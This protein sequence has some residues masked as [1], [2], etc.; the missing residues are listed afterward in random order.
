[1]IVL[2]VVFSKSVPLRGCAEAVRFESV[3][4]RYCL[5]ESPS[6]NA[7]VSFARTVQYS[8]QNRMQIYHQLDA[9]DISIN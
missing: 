2:F 1:M 5:R 8:L 4:L 9:A 6:C 7:R 3:V